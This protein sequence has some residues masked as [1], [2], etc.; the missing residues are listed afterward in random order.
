MQKFVILV[1]EPFGIV[2][3]IVWK[4]GTTLNPII[5]IFLP[6]DRNF[7]SLKLNSALQSSFL[8]FYYVYVNIFSN[9]ILTLLNVFTRASL[10]ALLQVI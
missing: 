5:F 8:C 7:T 6:L 3:K 10:K 9:Y 2:E 1:K 4:L